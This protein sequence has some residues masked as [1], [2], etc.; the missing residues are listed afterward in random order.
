MVDDSD[1]IF[2]HW[3]GVEPPIKPSEYVWRHF[4]FGI[5]QDP[6]AVA[7][8]GHLDLDL[9]MWGSDIP[10]S[11]SS[12]PETRRWLD[13]IFEG[14]PADVRHQVLVDNPCR[15]WH[16]DPAALTSAPAA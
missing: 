3:H 14:C 15:I 13:E 12:F 2:R 9:I 11:V 5:V 16:L 6:L 8:R 10:H 4:S 7:R 1:Q